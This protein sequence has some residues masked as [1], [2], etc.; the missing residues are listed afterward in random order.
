MKIIRNGVEFELTEKEMQKAKNEIELALVKDV[1]GDGSQLGIDK[2][3]MDDFYEEILVRLQDSNE[4]E[5]C[6]YIEY[7]ADDLAEE[8][9]EEELLEEEDEEE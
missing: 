1:V 6:R 2:E 4:V 8:W 3:R 5:N 7:L 9:H